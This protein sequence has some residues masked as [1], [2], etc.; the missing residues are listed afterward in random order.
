MQQPSL[1]PAQG[2]PAASAPH[3]AQVAPTAQAAAP[4][5]PPAATGAPVDVA[6][7]MDA[8]VS[9][10]GTDLNWRKSIVDMMKALDLDSSLEARKELAD[11]F[12][13]TGDKSDSA[14]MNVWL[15][16]ELMRKLAENGGR[17]PAELTD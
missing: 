9:K 5:S 7:V 17:V 13:Y 3:S 10:H 1:T 14:T 15:H 8:A 16:K 4:V 6:A 2:G 11:E 12:A